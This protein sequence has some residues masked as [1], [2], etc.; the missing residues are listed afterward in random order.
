MSLRFDHGF[1]TVL[2][3]CEGCPARW[4]QLCSP[5][6]A[7]HAARLHLEIVH[8]APDDPTRL[9]F[10]SASRQRARRAR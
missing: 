8:P 10:L 5:S 6:G 9:R 7:D 2:V 4:R 1:S 3:V